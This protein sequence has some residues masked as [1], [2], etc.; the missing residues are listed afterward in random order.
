MAGNNRFGS[1]GKEKK[2]KEC[3]LPYI[4]RRKHPRYL[5][6]QPIEYHHPESPATRYGHTINLSESGL[7]AAVSEQMEAG[8]EFKV[9]IHF[10][11]GSR[12]AAIQAAV[13]VIWAEN[14]ARDDGFYHFGGMITNISL[15]D[16]SRLRCFLGQFSL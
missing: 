10:S 12:L 8:K 14:Q 2:Q 11:S 16:I 5:V 15:Q 7:E 6:H 1:G 3:P 4:E 9:K 13:R